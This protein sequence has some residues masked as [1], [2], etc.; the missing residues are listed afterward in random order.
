M[1]DDG[2][3][4]LRLPPLGNKSGSFRTLDKV[5]IEKSLIKYK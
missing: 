5:M 4:L 2:N 1:K 3:G